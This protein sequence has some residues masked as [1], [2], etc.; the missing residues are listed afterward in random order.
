MS[1]I[2]FTN[3]TSKH[4]Y[5]TKCTELNSLELIADTEGFDRIDILYAYSFD[6]VNYQTFDTVD[7]LIYAVKTDQSPYAYIYIRLSISPISLNRTQT[8]AF[9]DLN[10]IILNGDHVQIVS[11][12]QIKNTDNILQNYNDR[13]LYQPYRGMDSA[14]E[15]NRKLSLGV[16][17][18][19]GHKCTYF[20]TEPEQETRS[21]IFKSYRL[22]KVKEYKE[23]QV[24][25]KDNELPD[26]R[27]NFSEWDYDFFDQLEVH[28]VIEHYAEVFGEDKIPNAD[29]YLFLPLTKRMYQ[30]NTVN[31]VKKFMNKSTY[32]QAVLTKWD[33]R[34]DVD[35]SV[36][37]DMLPD[38]VDKVEDVDTE[39]QMIE[40]VN[41][42]KS[43]NT[44]T[45]EHSISEDSIVINNLEVLKFMFDFSDRTNTTVVDEYTFTTNKEFAVGFW[46]RSNTVKSLNVFDVRD[47]D[48][49]LIMSLKINRLGFMTVDYS[50]VLIDHELT[51]SGTA[52]QPNTKYAIFFNYVNSE[53]AKY[54]TITVLNDKFESIQENF[55]QD[56]E[57][58]VTTSALQL[59]GNMSIGNLRVLKTFVKKSD[60]QNIMSDMLPNVQNYF[61]IANAVPT[62]KSD[63]YKVN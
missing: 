22:S 37:V 35:S 26:N 34:A 4:L 59:Y 20:R 15:L 31:E 27:T 44:P 63:R 18:I 40:Y 21:I 32:Y 28:I 62:V 60:I 1:L 47:T 24:L 61:A 25:I 56:V 58:I 10:S 9:Y 43:Y 2:S 8:H 14:H 41:A 30:I 57:N 49:K 48:G 13:N 53:K 54:L 16:S 38:M 11:V 6:D 33:D 42:T 23:L 46:F 52:L 39:L 36:A 45:T 17:R 7:K 29:D 51:A 55:T 19:F 50:T 12:E 5:I 3:S